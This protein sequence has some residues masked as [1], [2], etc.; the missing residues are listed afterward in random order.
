[1]INRITGVETVGGRR[2]APPGFILPDRSAQ[3]D[4]WKELRG[5]IEKYI[6]DHPVMSLAIGVTVG[7]LLGCLIKR[8]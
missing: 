5:R 8:R 4:Q 3:D 7:I 2:P 6:G 1:V